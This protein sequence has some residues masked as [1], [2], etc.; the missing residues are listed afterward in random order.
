[1]SI[2]DLISALVC[3]ALL[4][5]FFKLGFARAVKSL[6]CLVVA[7]P[8]AYFLVDP[9][10]NWL[11][12]LSISE[13]L[14]LP[15]VVFAVLLIVIYSFL[16]TLLPSLFS[17]NE[18]RV[19][20][21]LALLPGFLVVLMIFCLICQMAFSFVG[22]EKLT[23]SSSACSKLVEVNPLGIFDRYGFVSRDVLSDDLILSGEDGEVILVENL[24]SS[25]IS[26]YALEGEMIDSVNKLRLENDVEILSRDGE[27]DKLA[28]EYA[29]DILVQ[30][31]FAH[32]DNSGSLPKDRALARG[33]NFDY[34]GE[35]LA[36]ANNISSAYQGLSASKRHR[37]N[38]VQPLFR[39]IGI[40]V[41]KIN[42]SLLIVQEFSN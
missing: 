41:L 2:V 6:I 8:L 36:I 1:M 18:S 25:G 35:N 23:K 33:I 38:L 9:I 5:A 13:N 28:S 34:F 37:E 21:F 20:A 27:L 11:N 40:C 30:K 4:F 19:S 22:K 14:Y 39:K 32:L 7:Y 10:I 17:K 12:K 3:L 42:N 24:P 15:S 31:R 29:R 16:Y 26:A